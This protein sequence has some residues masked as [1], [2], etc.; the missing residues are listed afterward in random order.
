FD[1]A[2]PV[3]VADG[4]VAVVTGRGQI[5][6]GQTLGYAVVEA[7]AGGAG[8]TTAQIGEQSVA[9]MVLETASLTD[10]PRLRISAPADGAAAWGTV[11]VGVTWWRPGVRAGA[12]P[13]LRIGTPA[14]DARLRAKW[15]N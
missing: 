10:S 15:T 12:A 4:N 7:A 6:A 13:V 8:A 5:L 11:G 3:S 1:R 2:V 9:L 14:G